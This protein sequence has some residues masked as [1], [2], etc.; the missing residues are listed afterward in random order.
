[1]ENYRWPDLV[2]Y[3]SDWLRYRPGYLRTPGIQAAVRRRG[4]L[5]LSTVSGLADVNR[6]DPL[7]EQHLFRVASHSKS[8]ATVAILQLVSRGA[9]RLDD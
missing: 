3:Y 5:V 2:D 4:E 8:F 1:M 9:L 6:G 7:T